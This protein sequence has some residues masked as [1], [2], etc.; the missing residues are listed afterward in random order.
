[1]PKTKMNWVDR[2]L[3]R[4]ACSKLVRGNYVLV[5]R[6]F[7]IPARRLSYPRSVCGRF[8]ILLPCGMRR[9]GCETIF[10]RGNLPSRGRSVFGVFALSSPV[11]GDPLQVLL[12]V[13]L[14]CIWSLSASVG[15]D[16]NL[17]FCRFFIGSIC[18]QSELLGWISNSNLERCELAFQDF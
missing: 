9:G 18:K 7:F 8:P 4:G 5:W 6:N 17:A 2:L 3:V 1:M 16:A 14:V 10:S 15:V 13:C 12:S 11:E